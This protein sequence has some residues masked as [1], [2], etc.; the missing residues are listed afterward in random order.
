MDHFHQTRPRISVNVEPEVS[1]PPFISDDAIFLRRCQ[2]AA[3]P[4]PKV[5]TGSAR[6]QL[7]VSLGQLDKGDQDSDA[8]VEP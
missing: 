5:K 8:I 3:A 7:A 6:T 4:D 1:T 2:L